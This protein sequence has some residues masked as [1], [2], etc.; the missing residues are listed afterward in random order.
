MAKSAKAKIGK[1][2]KATLVLLDS[3]GITTK[4]DL[5]IGKTKGDKP[6]LTVIKETPIIQPYGSLYLKS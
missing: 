1:T 4:I 2:T 3:Q 5:K 6:K